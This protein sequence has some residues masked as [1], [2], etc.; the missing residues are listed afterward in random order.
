MARR[1]R[2]INGRCE[3]GEGGGNRTER[4][5]VNNNNV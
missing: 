2:S 3:G 5:G 4:G 1:K